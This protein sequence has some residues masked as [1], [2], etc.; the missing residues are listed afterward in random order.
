MAC[1]VKHSQSPPI[2]K[3]QPIGDRLE[4]AVDMSGRQENLTPVKARSEGMAYD[5]LEA[6]HKEVL[7]RDRVHTAREESHQKKELENRKRKEV[8]LSPVFIFSPMIPVISTDCQ[9]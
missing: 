7:N 4:S 1:S 9:S 3:Q 8:R 6:E 2:V 5:L